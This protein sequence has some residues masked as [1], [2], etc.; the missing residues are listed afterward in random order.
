MSRVNLGF[1]ELC[2]VGT[3]Y[4][5][6]RRL[7]LLISVRSF[8]R[9]M[10]ERIVPGQSPHEDLSLG[11]HVDRCSPLY[12]IIEKMKGKEGEEQEEEMRSMSRVDALSRAVVLA[13]S[14]LIR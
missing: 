14:G 1:E 5:H 12:F 10:D 11:R 8:A 4:I 2:L 7:Y 13:G 3:Y 6:P 9:V